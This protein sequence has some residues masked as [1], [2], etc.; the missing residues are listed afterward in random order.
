MELI[1]KYF[2][3]LSREQTEQ[4][5]LLSEGYRY[6]NDKINVIS[7]KDIS[8]LEE[9]HLLHSL[10]IA[11]FISFAPGSK[12]LDVGTG[13]GL[14]GL[15]LAIMHPAT[16]FLLV[17]SIGKKILVVNDLIKRTGLSNVKAI[18]A[19][20]ETLTEKFHFIV[21][22]AVTDFPT[23]VAWTRKLVSSEQFSPV[24]NG[25]IYLKG[26]DLGSELAPFTGRIVIR[27]IPEW[28]AEPFFETKKVIYLPLTP[29]GEKS[30]KNKSSH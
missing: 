20:A 21:S 28:F 26:G 13:G 10:A 6:W 7:R 2:P 8:L 11:R 3:G 22:R 15:P 18:Q 27:D 12:V 5:R 30:G 25:I 1:G 29:A 23:F 16:E 19:R 9:R 4:F 17:D 24:P 14:P